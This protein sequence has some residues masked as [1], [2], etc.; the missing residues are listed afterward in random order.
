MTVSLI[1]VGLSVLRMGASDDGVTRDGL[2]EPVTSASLAIS[3]VRRSSMVW[4]FSRPWSFC[5][6]CS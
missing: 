1:G 2:I 4:R 6:N 5:S 3:E